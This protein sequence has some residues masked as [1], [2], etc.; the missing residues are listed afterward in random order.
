MKP[1]FLEELVETW[2]SDSRPGE[3]AFTTPDFDKIDKILKE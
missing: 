1:P 3:M 2:S